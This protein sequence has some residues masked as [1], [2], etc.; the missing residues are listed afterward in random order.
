MTETNADVYP[1]TAAFEKEFKDLSKDAVYRKTFRVMVHNIG[2]YEHGSADLGGIKL[3]EYVGVCKDILLT[4][5]E[6][7]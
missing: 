4:L 3:R 5:R 7:G 6:M 1:I 2:E